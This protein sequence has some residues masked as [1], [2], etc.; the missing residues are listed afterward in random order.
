MNYREQLRRKMGI[1]LNESIELPDVEEA[2]QFEEIVDDPSLS[3]LSD[4][5]TKRFYEDDE[6]I[7]IEPE[8]EGGEQ[9]DETPAGTME[10]PMVGGDEDEE[11]EQPEITSDPDDM[12]GDMGGGVGISLTP[13]QK[14]AQDMEKVAEKILDKVMTPV[15]REANELEESDIQNGMM[16]RNLYTY[17]YQNKDKIAK[18]MAK[19]V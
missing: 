5:I 7:D 13:E 14:K 11:E 1:R 10:D 19:G 3:S 16:M 15:R 18:F 6:E 2:Q 8:D 4:S 12:E 9:E 17:L